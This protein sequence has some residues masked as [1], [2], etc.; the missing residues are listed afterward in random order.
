MRLPI[1]LALLLTP[2]FVS[3]TVA[4]QPNILFIYSDDHASHAMS[5]Y[6]SKINQTPNL[7]RIAAEGM[8]FNNCFCTN[9]ICGPSRA[10]VLT[11]KHSHKNGFMDNRSKFDGS[12][13]TVPKLLKQAGY[14]TAMIGKWHLVSDPTGFDHWEILPGQGAY[15]NPP[16]I[17]NGKRVK[18]EGYATEIIT[19]RALDWLKEERDTS[20]PFLLMYQHKSPHREWQPS[21]ETMANYKDTTIPEPSTLF[22][23]YSGRGRAAHEQDMTIAKTMT[24]LDLKFEP[25]QNMSPEQLNLWNQTYAKENAEFEAADLTAEQ[26]IKWRYQR[27]MKDYLRCVDSM[28]TNIG[29]VLD[30][31]KDS[32]LEENTIVI[33][34]SDQGF[35]LGDHGW[36]DKRFMYEPSLRQPLLVK[37]PRVVKAGSTN[38]HLVSNLDFAETMLEAAGVEIPDEMQGRSM[39]PLLKGDSP[40]DWR[41]SHYYHYYEYPAVHSV[42]RHRGVRSERYKLIHFYQIDEWEFYDLEKD[43]DELKSVYKDPAYAEE[44]Q[45]HH[46][47]LDDLTKQYDVPKDVTPLGD[48]DILFEK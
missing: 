22:D 31:L 33:Y 42:H 10:V 20:K 3:R 41:K 7:D 39:V 46:Q 1:V 11:G 4:A 14:Q 28:D 9:S 16:M 17:R 36:F 15:Y 27:Y 48:K 13:V 23:D 25:P 6:G 34:S 37:W 45:R 21:P 29:R 18:Y 47:L 24:R 2:L 44:I 38:D 26:V 12:Q 19:D 40:S 8:R 35:Y 43:P 30:Y 5:C 32:G